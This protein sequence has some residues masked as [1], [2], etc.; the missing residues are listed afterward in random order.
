MDI[1]TLNHGCVDQLSTV[2]CAR[3]RNHKQCSLPENRQGCALT[4]GA[5]GQLLLPPPPPAPPPSA[6]AL[7][8]SY[9]RY[10][11]C[12]EGTTY[13]CTETQIWVKRGCR[14]VFTCGGIP[15]TCG[16][17]SLQSAACPCGDSSLARADATNAP[18]TDAKNATFWSTRP[19]VIT[20]VHIPKTAG[21]SLHMSLNNDLGAHID[22]YGWVAISGSILNPTRI[23][24]DENCLRDVTY[25]RDTYGSGLPA[26]QKK[27][28]PLRR[29][30]R[31]AFFRSPRT[32]VYS[33]FLECRE[34]WAKTRSRHMQ[35]ETSDQAQR[36]DEA[37]RLKA[38][39][40]RNVDAVNG[41]VAA[42]FGAWLHTFETQPTHHGWGC[43]NPH[44]MQA[45]ALTCCSAAKCANHNTH[46][47]TSSGEAAPS[48]TAAI[49]ALDE[50][51]VVGL[52]EHYALSLCL[53]IHRLR[54]IPPSSCF[55]HPLGHVNEGSLPPP[56]PGGVGNGTGSTM[57]SGVAAVASA[58]GRTSKRGA[59]K[60]PHLRSRSSS[61]ALVNMPHHFPTIDALTTIDRQ[62]YAAAR[63]RFW[64]DV[65][66]M[67]RHFGQ[68]LP[69]DGVCV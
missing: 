52:Q 35:H 19:P 10:V 11:P 34:V 43:Y 60:T 4:C 18:A 46:L 8:R 39:F 2:V 29:T 55:C 31:I 13:G 48:L 33:Q 9:S 63:A 36:V 1:H 45:R 44:N 24:G 26:S 23:S 12:V 53:T 17:Y 21:S 57:T 7:V 15:V 22:M 30:F 69:P 65:A 56:T 37:N 58:G 6:C 28:A 16:H 54:R 14:G 25:A 41:S 47:I 50:I 5:C 42:D 27:K 49:A 20:L 40:P 64:R 67:E 51:D 68:R 59:P 3:A 66:D 32:H 38:D 61:A 62:V